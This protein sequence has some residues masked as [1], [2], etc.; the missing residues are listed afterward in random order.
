MFYE[1]LST[2]E[3]DETKE[4]LLSNEFITSLVEK[5]ITK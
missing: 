4:K 5:K 3:D 2:L 1:S